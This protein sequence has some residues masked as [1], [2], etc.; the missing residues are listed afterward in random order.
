VEQANLEATE[1]LRLAL[2]AA[3]MGIFDWDLPANHITWSRRHEE[4]WGFAPGEFAGT[5]EAFASRVHPGDQPAIDA[6]VAACIRNRAPFF[7]E[8]R[9]TVPDGPTRWISGRGE[10]TF[11][12]A[13]QPLR[14]RGVVVDVTER[15]EAEAALRAS[16]QRFE[17]LVNATTEAIQIIDASGR[18][19]YVNPAACALW[20]YSRDEFLRLTVADVIV[21]DRHDQIRQT[22]DSVVQ[23]ETFLRE[24]RLR[25]KD[26]SVFVGETNASVLP[27]GRIISV[28]R[29]ITERKHTEERLREYTD[30]LRALT[31][32]VHAIREEEGTRIARELH[33]ELGQS[34]TGL[35]I[36]VS[37][38]DK[39]LRSFGDGDAVSDMRAKTSAMA[40]QID[41]TVQTVRRISSELRPTVLDDLGLGAAIEWQVQE[42]QKRTGIQCAVSLLAETVSIGPDRATVVYRIL[43]ESLT[44]VARH[45]RAKTISVSLAREVDDL[46]L[47]VADDGV[48]FG[49]LAVRH[50]LGI[51]GM[52]ERAQALGG[53]VTVGEADTRGTA[54]TARIPLTDG[55]PRGDAP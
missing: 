38:I 35:R 32:R 48:G 2:E 44:N 18:F 21:P 15:R 27:D 16:E 11:D 53:S 52:K 55:R 6:A 30:A 25:R 1:R 13:G 14:M 12:P 33:D 40:R 34:L 26:G 49:G 41:E 39:R 45:A 10:F 36:D 29:D 22:I 17:T 37:W 47:R 4:L 19:Q 46:V 8:F 28:M 24:W 50:S 42:F 31:E 23:G 43:L 20:G 54:V 5:Y 7:K 51:L 9:V 3:H